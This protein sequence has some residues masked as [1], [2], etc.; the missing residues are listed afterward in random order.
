MKQLSKIQQVPITCDMQQWFEILETKYRIK[1]N[2]FIRDAIIEKFKRD[3]PKLRLKLE[4]DK[5][6]V[7][8]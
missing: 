1:R 5:N 2:R 6:K 3:T 7:P 4:S 8:F